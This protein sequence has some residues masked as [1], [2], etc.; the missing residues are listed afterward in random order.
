MSLIYWF[1]TIQGIEDDIRFALNRAEYPC[2]FDSGKRMLESA[3][4][5][6]NWVGRR[7]MIGYEMFLKYDNRCQEMERLYK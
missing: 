5:K 3:R 4:D 2:D 7:R 6:I 1:K